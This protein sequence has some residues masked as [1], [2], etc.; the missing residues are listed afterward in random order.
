M[1]DT[2]KKISENSV[3]MKYII[4]VIINHERNLY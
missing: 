3:I 4:K 1:D 2:L